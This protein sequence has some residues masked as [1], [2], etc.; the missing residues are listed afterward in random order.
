[1]QGERDSNSSAD[2]RV[3]EANLTEFIG[4]IRATYGADLPF[5]IGQLSE[6][7]TGTNGSDGTREFIRAAQANVAAALPNTELVVTNS[8]GLKSDNLHFNAAGQQ[9]LGNAFASQL[10]SLIVPEPTSVSIALVALGGL[11]APRRGLAWKL[12]G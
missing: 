6:N 1:M 8:F 11:L 5:V 3:Y 4:D 12:W 10:Q 9:D 2:A 7:Q